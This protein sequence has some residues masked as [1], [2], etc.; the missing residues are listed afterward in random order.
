M[1]NYIQPP[2]S[3]LRQCGRAIADFDM[4]RE[5]DRLLLGVSG[6]KNSLSLLHAHFQRHAPIAFEIEAVTIDPQTEE[7]D[8]SPLKAVM[9]DTRVQYH[10]VEQPILELAKTHIGKP[11]YCAFCS[12]MKRGLVY[13]TARDNGDNGYSVLVLARHLDN[14]AESFFMSAFFGGKLKTMKAH[15]LNDAGDV[16]IIRPL[17]YARELQL[18]DF[19]KATGLPV[20]A[21]NCPACFSKP[22]ERQHAKELLAAEEQRNPQMFKTLKTTLMPLMSN[23]FQ[24]TQ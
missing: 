2:K 10:Y 1:I 21:E 19:A 3:L 7:F 16:R 13:K 22:T 5:G 6:G 20:I 9:Q 18:A 17:V 12:R 14:L 8:P 11:S 15:Y 23:G 4:I 24:A